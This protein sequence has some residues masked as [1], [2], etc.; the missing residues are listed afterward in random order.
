M[1]DTCHHAHEVH[2]ALKG[3]T[4]SRDADWGE[5]ACLAP[6]LSSPP[7]SSPSSAGCSFL[8][9]PMRSGRWDEEALC[10]GPGSLGG[11]G[12]RLGLG[13]G[14]QL[15]AAASRWNFLTNTKSGGPQLP[16]ALG[17]EGALSSFSKQVRGAWAVTHAGGP[18]DRGRR[19]RW[20]RIGWRRR[21]SRF[22]LGN[23]E[24]R[25]RVSRIFQPRICGC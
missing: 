9:V 25:A 15:R 17:G 2:H 14:L 8:H 12:R 3:V 23:P 1:Q 11:R 21:D 16:Q 24:L 19:V 20:A 13:R 22:P 10:P 18:L 4:H 7:P 6:G 5:R